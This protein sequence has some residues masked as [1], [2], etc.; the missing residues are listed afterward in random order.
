[1]ELKQSIIK[2]VT[3]Y[4]VVMK[5]SSHEVE[6][7]IDLTLYLYTQDVLELEQWEITEIIQGI[8]EDL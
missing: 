3:E 5:S 6:L 1:M 7:I 4:A 8:M 2:E